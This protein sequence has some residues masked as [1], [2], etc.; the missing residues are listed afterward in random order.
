MVLK[1]RI[2]ILSF[3]LTCVSLTQAAAPRIVET[4]PEMGA[5][6]V[7]PALR[8]IK[9]V[10]DQDMS[11]AAYS[12]CGG[13]DNFPETRGKPIWKNARTCVLPVK[14]R[15]NHEYAL[16]INCPSAQGFRAKDGT[17]AE[18]TLFRFKTRSE[19][20]ASPSAAGEELKAA[21]RESVEL[22]RTLI[23]D[24]Y[25]YRDLRNVEWDSVF[26]RHSPRLI[27]ART[28][29]EFAKAAGRMLAP[30][31]DIH[32][33]LK[34]GDEWVGTYSRRVSANINVRGLS[35]L[36]PNFEQLGKYVAKGH[37]ES[38]IGYLA[39]HSWKK[40]EVE[41]ALT[42]LQAFMDYDGLIIDVRANSGGSEIEARKIAANFVAQPVIYAKH[43]VIVPGADGVVQ[44]RTLEP[45]NAGSRYQGRV[46][47]LSGQY[48]MSSCEAFI[49][50]MKQAAGC[51]IIGET[52]YGSSGNP[53]PY[54]LPNGVTI[55]VPSWR[56]MLPTGEVFEGKGI[57]PDITVKTKRTDFM[58][59]DP[60]LQRALKELGQQ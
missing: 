27:E 50:M 39:I 58:T 31:R 47:V 42:A 38:K 48:V 23:K 59:G 10:F 36:V 22:L 32:L 7:D 40:E 51:K 21:N 41:S 33:T 35:Q 26:K 9:V 44:N 55:N 45:A 13:G 60:V 46:V 37:W 1:R 53:Q 28:S 17:P 34:V 15:P 16:S 4:V 56:A 11:R 14:L 29:M 2:L 24:H 25:S 3:C 30:A 43:E 49:L 20:P 19:G 18:N 57:K 5:T 52:T 12:W 54:E 8:Q 6:D